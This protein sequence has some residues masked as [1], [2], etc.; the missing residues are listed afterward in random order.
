MPATRSRA[1]LSRTKSAPAFARLSAQGFPSPQP[2]PG[3]RGSRLCRL[4][5]RFHPPPND[6]LSLWER[7]RVRASPGTGQNL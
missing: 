6:P 7:A 5:L 4:M 2:S 1:E 3:G